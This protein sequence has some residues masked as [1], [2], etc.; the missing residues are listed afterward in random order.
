MGRFPFPFLPS[1]LDCISKSYPIQKCQILALLFCKGF[2]L[3]Q[4]LT[5]VKFSTFCR[6]YNS[7]QVFAWE[8]INGR[9][10]K[11]LQGKRVWNVFSRFCFE[12]LLFS[13]QP[14]RLVKFQTAR[15]SQN[16][17]MDPP[18]QQYFQTGAYLFRCYREKNLGGI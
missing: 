16:S 4:E 13:A 17:Q 8:G 14:M 1:L 6:E 5:A 12:V 7:E 10:G 15:A 9:L 2:V 18:C 3:V 11:N